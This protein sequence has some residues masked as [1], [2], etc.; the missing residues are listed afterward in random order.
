MS[1]STTVSN[2]LSEKDR[3]LSIATNHLKNAEINPLNKQL[4]TKFIQQLTAEGLT[5]DRQIKYIYTT[6]NL[7]RWFHNK[8]FKQVAKDDIVTVIGDLHKKEYSE[9]TKRDYRIVLKRLIKYVQEQEGKIFQK[10]EY[11]S[12]VAWLDCTVKK[13]RQKLPKELL[14]IEDIKKLS[15]GTLNLRDKTFIL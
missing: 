7:S 11:P 14:S 2:R 8:L 4:I 10:H 3:A 6:V 13:S 9:W 15:E 5:K 1:L 12:E